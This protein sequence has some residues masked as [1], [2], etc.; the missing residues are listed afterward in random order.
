[1]STSPQ[2]SIV[3]PFLNAEK[4]LDE[5]IQSV[6]AQ[7]YSFWEL[8]LVDDGSTDGSTVIAKQYVKRDAA[9]VRYLDHP[10]HKNQG[11]PA[12]RNLGLSHARGEFVAFLDADDVWLPDKL[13][14]QMAVLQSQ[15]L[16]MMVYGPSRRWYSWTGR[17]EDA[18][19]DYLP[20]LGVQANALLQPPILL[21]LSL[22]RKATTPCPSNVLLRRDVIE[23]VG[24]FEESFRGPCHLYEDQAFF[25]KV[26]VRHPVWVSDRQWDKY[27]RHPDS[28]AAV[29]KG[30]GQGVE[31]RGVY[32]R[33]LADYLDREGIEDR[34]LCRALEGQLWSYRH[35]VLAMVR[36]L[37]TR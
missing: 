13:A 6:F 33:W 2:V 14:E 37:A 26:V 36:Q 12:S 11:L 19:R 7:T 8:L 22:E 25:A 31:V 23:K 3:I 28:V 16:A 20:N 29:V 10:Q 32:L 24:G 30:R 27:R 21:T 18:E 5:A 15:P 4:F 34:D 9:R 17:P 35:P 1:V